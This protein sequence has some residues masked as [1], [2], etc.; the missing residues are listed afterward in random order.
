MA[1]LSYDNAS[2]Y[3]WSNIQQRTW[4]YGG[5]SPFGTDLHLQILTQIDA[6]NAHSA[7]AA[8]VTKT[9]S[10]VRDQTIHDLL[11]GTAEFPYCNRTDP[12]QVAKMLQEGRAIIANIDLSPDEGKSLQKRVDANM[13]L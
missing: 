11:K 5:C 1:E 8:R 2:F 9:L 13:G 12:E 6:I 4:D 3:G 10:R 7:F